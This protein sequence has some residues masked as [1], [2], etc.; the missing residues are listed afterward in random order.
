MKD[1]AENRQQ[2]RVG[3]QLADVAGMARRP[4]QNSQQLVAVGLGP[5][6]RQ[7]PG[8]EQ[9]SVSGV[10]PIAHEALRGE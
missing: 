9:L 10:E 1:N 8:T 2:E 7:Q 4:G 6:L 5:L 3:T